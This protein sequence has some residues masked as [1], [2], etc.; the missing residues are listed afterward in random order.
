M[1][2][3]YLLKELADLESLREKYM[4]TW[5]EDH[6]KRE[7]Y[8]LKKRIESLSTIEGLKTELDKIQAEYDR[9]VEYRDVFKGKKKRREIE[10]KE[11]EPRLVIINEIKEEISK[12]L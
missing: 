4:G 3:N 9:A 2:N 10:K 12:K 5:D 7:I 1:N 8:F 6:F 11:I